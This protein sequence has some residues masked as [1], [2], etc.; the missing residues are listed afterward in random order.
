MILDH[1]IFI[2]TIVAVLMALHGRDFL[3]AAFLILFSH[4]FALLVLPSSNEWAV[5]ESWLYTLIIKDLILISLFGFMLNRHCFIIMLTF[6]ASC[7][8]HQFLLAQANTGIV[9]NL[10][11]LA[12]R[13]DFMKF[14][15]IVQLSTLY[16]AILTGGD[17]D[18]GKRAQ[19]NMLF[20]NHRYNQF[21]CQKTHKVAQ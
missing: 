17:S 21:F 15:V 5:F 9:D 13:P 2:A 12:V 14:I 8:F 19:H 4:A 6:V 1:A 20:S 11:L 3:F 7:V 16:H 18:G 10:T